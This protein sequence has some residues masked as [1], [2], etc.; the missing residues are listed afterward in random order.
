MAKK[1]DTI[2][3]KLELS[4]EREYKQ[5]CKEVGSALQ[6]IGS[7][8]KLLSAQY[9]DNA[10]SVDALRKKQDLLKKELTEYEKKAD[11][12]SKALED[13]E[14][15]GKG[16]T[17][18]AQK[19]RTALNNTKTQIIRTNREI[20]SIDRNLGEM[21]QELDDTTEGVQDFGDALEDTE[22]SSK[23]FSGL[24]GGLQ[25]TLSGFGVNI[26]AAL[27]PAALSIGAIGTAIGA[28]A[29][30]CVESA[31]EMETA[32]NSF[33]AKTGI[34]KDDVGE[35]GDVL[36]DIYVSGLGDSLDDVAQAMATIA[37]TTGELQPEKLQ[38]MTESGLLLE[39]T[40]GFDIQEQIRAVTQL[41][42]RFGVS[43]EEA[44]NLIAQGAQGG[45]DKNGG[46]LD[47][48]NEY[49]QYFEGLG[50]TAEQ[51]FNALKSGVDSG[52][53]SVDKLGDA[54]KEF[55]LRVQD[56]SETTKSALKTLGF[57]ATEVATEI[58]KGGTNAQTATLQILEALADIEDPIEQQRLGVELFGTQ[59]EDLGTQA[60][61]AMANIDGAISTTTQALDD[62]NE[63]SLDTVEGKA[64][65]AGR[66][67][68]AVM[69][70]LGG[71]GAAVSSVFYDGAY[72]ALDGAEI[73]IDG[74]TESW[75][76]GTKAMST[77][78]GLLK[79]AAK[80]A[81]S[82]MQGSVVQTGYG[83]GEDLAKEW[84]T[85]IPKLQAG[86]YDL[87]RSGDNM[88]QALMDSIETSSVTAMESATGA[89]E[90]GNKSLQTSWKKI[91]KNAMTEWTEVHDV[92]QKENEA[93]TQDVHTEWFL[94][95]D[96]VNALWSKGEDD[97]HEQWQGIAAAPIEETESAQEGL[98]SAWKVMTDGAAASFEQLNPLTKKTLQSATEN[99]TTE[100]GKMKNAFNFTWKLPSF[101]LPKINID[102]E[103]TVWGLKIPKLSVSWNAL[104]GI[105]DKPTLLQS[106]AGL[107]G[108]GEKG[109]EAILPL[110]TLW[111]ELDARL[112]RSMRKFAAE[113]STDVMRGA[114]HMQQDTL[115]MVAGTSNRGNV[116]ITQNIYA[117]ETSYAEQQRLAARNFRQIAREMTL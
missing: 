72:Y 48:I 57:N 56:G 116:S 76:R 32:I 52:A 47:S 94:C 4:G 113:I 30:K 107:Q 63:L 115:R 6:E 80:K 58:G 97:A 22:G 37:Q 51:M 54:F 111:K 112:D 31:A 74:A 78:I 21:G 19:L 88:F 69:A 64:E 13:L 95:M 108:V 117:N 70:K 16:N 67:L 9:E 75:D 12:A 83:G 86:F 28:A 38:E 42:N 92:V 62:L 60:V 103:D 73:M 27:N 61:L 8:M 106:S 53:F 29:V 85:E 98:A 18:E 68:E 59:W 79:I 50:F 34:A 44:F 90:Y 35:F 39:K 91:Y 71:L 102:W 84:E 23:G 1:E 104:G 93:A 33:A 99:V 87:A 89:W 81:F 11:A 55:Y 40:F 15:A 41:M 43:S 10:D 82:E 20:E 66:K 49:S 114:A 17:A 105:F 5:A 109:A 14:A 25:E 36:S 77:S 24:L 100:L 65:R 26:P 7:E 101:K 45:L 2:S 96:K 3:T 46:L 110:D